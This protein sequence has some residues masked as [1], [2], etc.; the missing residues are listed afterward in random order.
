MEIAPLWITFPALIGIIGARYLALS[1]ASYWY[2]Y[3]REGKPREKNRVSKEGLRPAQVRREIL[4]S[5]CTTVIFALAGV[6]ILE[7]YRAGIVPIYLRIE[8]WGWPYFFLSIALMIGLHE[9]YFYFT[10]RWMH[11]PKIFRRVH[12]VHHQSRNP[13]PFASFAFHPWEA[14][15]EAMA[16]P[17]IALLIPAHPAALLTFLLFMTVLGV[18]N[19]LGYEI[20]PPGSATHWFGRWWI[21]P[22]HHTQHHE[23]VRGNYGLYFTFW[24]RLLGTEFPDYAQRFETVVKP[25]GKEVALEAR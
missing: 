4:W 21:G 2:F 16:L 19:H 14:L 18:T 1:G 24:D 22:T 12:L 13:T 6:A 15:V 17:L 10:H 23:A 3:R 8:E 7:G 5:L 9:T 11:R 20:Y 25:A